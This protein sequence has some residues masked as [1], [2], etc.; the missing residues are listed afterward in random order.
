MGS[1]EH[2]GLFIDCS[3]NK[4]SSH[5]CKTYANAVLGDNNH[6]SIKDIEVSSLLVNRLSRSTGLL[7]RMILFKFGIML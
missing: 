1:D 4:G 3:L 5:C 2:Y 6:F 7:M